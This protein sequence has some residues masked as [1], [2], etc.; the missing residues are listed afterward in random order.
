MFG[1]FPPLSL[2]PFVMLDSVRVDCLDSRLP[3]ACRGK[4]LLF[5]EASLTAPVVVLARLMLGMM[6][7]G[8]ASL[9]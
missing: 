8:D 1:V 4:R 9:R 2:D 6:K 3:G 5:R 7:A